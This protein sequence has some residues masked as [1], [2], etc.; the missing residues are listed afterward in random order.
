MTNAAIVV[1]GPSEGSRLGECVLVCLH[2]IRWERRL[3]PHSLTDTEGEGGRGW[4]GREREERGGGN[5]VQS[6]ISVQVI[7]GL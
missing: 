7:H 3:V 4:R 1:D 6:S 2:H 5:G